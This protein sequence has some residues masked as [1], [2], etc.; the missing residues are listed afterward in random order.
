MYGRGNWNP[1][2]N[3]RAVG[4]CTSPQERHKRV[5]QVAQRLLARRDWQACRRTFRRRTTY[6]F[7]QEHASEADHL[8]RNVYLVRISDLRSI[9][10]RQRSHGEAGKPLRAAIQH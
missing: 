6:E 8:S 9:E 5:R 1:D 3:R 2:A 10:W 4:S 7:W